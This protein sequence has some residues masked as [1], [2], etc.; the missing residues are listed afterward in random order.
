MNS[1]NLNF[2]I[3]QYSLKDIEKLFDVSP[4]YT[5]SD[6]DIDQRIAKILVSAKNQ[7]DS[8]KYQNIHDFLIVAKQKYKIL[9]DEKKIEYDNIYPITD[10]L[11]T[12]LTDN[13]FL[14]HN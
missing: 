6:N 12:M 11:K 5:L 1:P 4:G 13:K 2:D 10:R 3:N 7:V 14:L 9:L 8:V